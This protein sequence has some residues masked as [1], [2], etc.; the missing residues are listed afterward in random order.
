MQS[1]GYVKAHPWGR[2]L[3]HRVSGKEV[4]VEEEQG[5]HEVNVDPHR[6]VGPDFSAG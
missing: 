2:Q 3:C 4:H 6:D 5:N 1:E